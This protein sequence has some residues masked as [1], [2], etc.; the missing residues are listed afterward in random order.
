M[1]VNF[2]YRQILPAVCMILATVACNPSPSS[3][4]SGEQHKNIVR[5]YFGEAWNQGKLEVLDSLLAPQYINHTPSTPNPPR[6]PGGLKPIIAAF[7]RAFP[8][9][10]F[11]I[12]DLIASDS[13]VVARVVMTGT[14]QD[15]LFQLPPTGKKVEVNQINIE[16]ISN[17][18]IVAHW[19]VTDELSLMRQL[20]FV[21]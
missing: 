16:K 3:P 10:H 14:Q 21:P 18:Q 2:F 13:M 19:R 9:L 20:G 11:E 6:G 7:R 12:K 8:D 17:G 5:R 15:S 1:I 4:S